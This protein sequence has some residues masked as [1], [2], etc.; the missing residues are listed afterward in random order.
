MEGLRALVEISATLPAM[1]VM[2]PLR[3]V[4][5]IVA[6][7][8]RRIGEVINLILHH[9]EFQKMEATWRGLFLVIDG[10]DRAAD[11]KVKALDVSK[12]EL[13]RALRK[14]RGTA[15]D[16]SPL[17][18]RIYDD[19]YGQFGGEPFGV[20]VGD[21]EFDHSP[22]DV[23]L[24][25]DIAQVA[26][27]AHV[28]FIS[29]AASSV[30]QMDS[31]AEL[32]NPRDLT[33]IFQTPEYA[34]WRA[35]RAS[36]DA[37]YIGLCLPHFLARLPYGHRTEPTEAF[38][39]EEDVDGP[40]AS[41]FLWGNPAYAMAA[42]IARAFHIY[43]WCVRIRGIDGGGVVE[44]LPTYHFPTADGDVDLRCSTEIALS[45]R[46]EAELANNGFIPMVHRKHA[47]H[48]AFVGAPSIQKPHVYEDAAA[49]ANAAMS[50]R[51]PY[52]F[53]TCRFA[54][55]L[56]CMVRDKVGS[57]MDRPQIA[58]WLQAW[59]N[60]YID[61][62][63]ETSSEDWKAAHPLAEGVIVVEAKD[64]APG[65]YE[66]KFYLRPHYQLEGT[67]ATIRLVSRLAQP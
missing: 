1:P 39:F 32:A 3:L 43:G 61:G 41:R 53:A 23:T 9:P 58:K 36:E 50:A 65:S 4:E 6:E 31:W 38:D 46:R 10:T 14:F 17:F 29:A 67:T 2:D 15:W 48:P 45:E 57:S 49:T 56:K 47:P 34:G 8:D 27:A 20:L 59:I 62:S 37:R 40:D 28:P 33:R 26:A 42:N 18:R 11:L 51:L 21:Y 52:M 25:G 16:Q 64:N 13:S 35:L 22:P 55:Y 19:E 30:M 7:L 54:H 44:G 12:R 60:N 63:P 24:L 66:A 5:G